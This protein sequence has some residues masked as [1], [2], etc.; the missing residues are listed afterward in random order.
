[1]ANW[2]AQGPGRIRLEHFHKFHGRPD[3]NFS[4]DEIGRDPRFLSRKGTQGSQDKHL[5]SLCFLCFLAAT[6]LIKLLWRC[7]RTSLPGD[8]GQSF[9]LGAAEFS[10]PSLV[11]VGSSDENG[12]C[13]RPSCL[14]VPSS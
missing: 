14:C 6:D 1:L 10:S 8:N 4:L 7:A 11:R 9:G 12:S 3:E 13:F 5:N 2:E